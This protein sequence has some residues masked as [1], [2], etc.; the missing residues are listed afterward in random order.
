M[1]IIDKRDLLN[2]YWHLLMPG[3]FNISGTSCQIYAGK[4]KKFSSA[5]ATA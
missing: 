4:K 5:V 3:V 2:F 1:L